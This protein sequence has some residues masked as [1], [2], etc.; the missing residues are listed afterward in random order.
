MFY[1]ELREVNADSTFIKILGDFN[2]IAIEQNS[3]VSQLLL[4]Y[5][6]TVFKQTEISGSLLDHVYI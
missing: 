1:Q 3:Q 2:I 4:D 6:E 5:V